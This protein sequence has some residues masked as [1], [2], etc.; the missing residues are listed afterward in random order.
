M[1]KNAKFSIDQIR[2]IQAKVKYPILLLQHRLKNLKL[3]Q[4]TMQKYCQIFMF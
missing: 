1:A 3:G 2:S 4:S